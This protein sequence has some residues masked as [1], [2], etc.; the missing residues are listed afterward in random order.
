LDFTILDLTIK[1][2]TKTVP[3]RLLK[4]CRQK[5]GC[6]KFTRKR[7]HCNAA[8]FREISVHLGADANWP[9]IR[10]GILSATYFHW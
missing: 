8:N 5:A 6:A 3:F 4:A 1:K 2:G 7:D 9:T 10:G